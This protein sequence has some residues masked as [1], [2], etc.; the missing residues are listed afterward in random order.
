MHNGI[1][2]FPAVDLNGPAEYFHIPDEATSQPMLEKKLP[3][4]AID[5][6]LHLLMD[7]PFGLYIDIRDQKRG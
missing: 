7:I 1:Q 4:F 5:G 6:H 2:Q 3:F